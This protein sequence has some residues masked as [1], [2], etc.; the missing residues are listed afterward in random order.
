MCKSETRKTE[1]LKQQRWRRE[2]RCFVSFLTHSFYFSE[3]F[4]FLAPPTYM[5]NWV[6]WWR[7]RFHNSLLSLLRSAETH[8][9]FHLGC[10]YNEN[11]F[12]FVTRIPNSKYCQMS[13]PRKP[14]NSILRYCIWRI[15]KSV[16]N[17]TNV[18]CK[19][20]LFRSPYAMINFCRNG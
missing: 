19:P 8:F 6:R 1:V 4:S 20:H 18:H 9:V 5:C 2:V 17:Q 3:Q 11:G 12:C 13:H 16:R 14:I 15:I 10:T 7:K